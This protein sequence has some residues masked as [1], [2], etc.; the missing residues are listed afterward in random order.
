MLDAAHVIMASASAGFQGIALG[1]IAEG[2]S[3]IMP[4]GTF[5][6]AAAS[7][8]N[9]PAGGGD[10]VSTPII[11]TGK[12]CADGA[13]VAGGGDDGVIADPLG[14]P[15]DDALGLIGDTTRCDG[16]ANDP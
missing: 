12:S 2:L 15:G 13:V 4:S 11:D 5:G 7:Y 16:I 10:C 9:A 1:P 6:A 8:G 14:A 3:S